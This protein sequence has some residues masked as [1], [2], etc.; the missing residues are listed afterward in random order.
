MPRRAF[1][2]I[3]LLVVIAIIGLLSSIAVVSMSTS[4]E[5]ARMA[6]GQQYEAQVYRAVGDDLVSQ[7]DMN[8]C[9]GTNVLDASGLG[10]NGTAN[11]GVSWSTNTPSGIGCAASFNGTNGAISIPYTSISNPSLT[12]SAWFNPASASSRTIL[13]FRSTLVRASATAIDWWP[14]VSVNQVTVAKA[15]SLNAWHQIVVD[16]NGTSY[17]IYLDG[18]LAGSGTAPAIN[19]ASSYN[20]IGI[21]NYGVG[22]S[23]SGL[24]DDVRVYGRSLTAA[25]VRSIYAEG[26][27]RRTALAQTPGLMPPPTR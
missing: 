2:L 18:G 11:A 5:K 4:R 26:R 12:Y 22:I 16:Q 27:A 24:L 15:I 6:R 13:A 9:S 7:W 19:D 3:E 23:W 25:E 8:D 1:T 17:S 14:N 20:A 21:D 10:H